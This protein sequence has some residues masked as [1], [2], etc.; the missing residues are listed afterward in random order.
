MIL[1]RCKIDQIGCSG[2]H[3]I[4]SLPLQIFSAD[5]FFLLLESLENG[6]VFSCARA[7]TRARP[8]GGRGRAAAGD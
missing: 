5:P 8:S 6:W 4:S 2:D 1:D 3:L 7:R